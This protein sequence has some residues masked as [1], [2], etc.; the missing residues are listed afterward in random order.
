MESLDKKL[1]NILDQ[2]SMIYLDSQ[3]KQTLEKKLENYNKSNILINEASQ[4]IELLK[5]EVIN[6]NIQQ[7]SDSS[8]QSHSKINEYISLLENR[9]PRFDE[10]LY[11]I[12][13]LKSMETELNSTSKI[14]DHVDNE[15]IYEEEEVGL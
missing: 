15:V 1:K 10:V 11:I 6:I 2:I 14:T 8:K 13:Q 9:N 3:K 4:L 5:K 7:P 12:Q